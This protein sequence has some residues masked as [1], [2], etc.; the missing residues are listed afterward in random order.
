VEFAKDADSLILAL[1]G[2]LSMDGNKHIRISF[3]SDFSK[4]ARGSNMSSHQ[5]QEYSDIEDLAN[6]QEFPEFCNNPRC[7][8]GCLKKEYCA[9]D[10]FYTKYP[11]YQST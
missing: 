1:V 8:K 11:N 10:R 3:S 4:K 2:G 9:I 5:A 7:K 6:E